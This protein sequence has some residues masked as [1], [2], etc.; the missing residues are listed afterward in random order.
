MFL[1]I[2]LSYRICTCVNDTTLVVLSGYVLNIR[3]FT[4]EL[5]ILSLIDSICE[6][7]CGNSP[8]DVFWGKQEGKQRIILALALSRY[9]MSDHYKGA[10][11]Q[12]KPLNRNVMHCLLLC[13][14]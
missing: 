8:I 13:A 9:W 11:Y 12:I 3:R 14:S 1:T 4:F 2:P 5:G 10:I 7:F 6:E